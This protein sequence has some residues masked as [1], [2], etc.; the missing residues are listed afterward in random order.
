MSDN[1]PDDTDTQENSPASG[2]TSN[3]SNTSATGAHLGYCHVCDRQ[4]PINQEEFTCSVCNGGFIELFENPAQPAAQQQQQR[5]Q[6]FAA[7][8]PSDGNLMSILP[9]LIPQM[10]GQI[11]TGQQQ[12][13]NIQNQHQPSTNSNQQPSVNQTGNSATRL[14]FIVPN[15]DP[16]GQVDLYGYVFKN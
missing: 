14:Q 7:R 16:G 11:G 15:S 1:I 12:N 10:L 6:I 8:M 9:M 5:P 13:I 2:A 3:M 4:V